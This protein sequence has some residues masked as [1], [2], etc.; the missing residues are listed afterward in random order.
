[1]KAIVVRPECH[2]PLKIRKFENIL[3]INDISNESA[4]VTVENILCHMVFTCL[5]DHK[6]LHLHVGMAMS[7]LSSVLSSVDTLFL[8]YTTANFLF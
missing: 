5:Y 2:K 1:M 3:N 4:C 7:S 6:N 8:F